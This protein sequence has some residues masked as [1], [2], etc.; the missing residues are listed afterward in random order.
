[1]WRFRYW[2]DFL[3]SDSH[4]LFL[5]GVLMFWGF[6]LCVVKPILLVKDWFSDLRNP[7]PPPLAP[8]VIPIEVAIRRRE[9]RELMNR[10]VNK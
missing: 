4:P 2:Y 5:I 1:M 3:R 9:L 7:T 10:A 6:M 8:N